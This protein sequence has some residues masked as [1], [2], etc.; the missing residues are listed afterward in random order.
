MRWGR[1]ISVLCLIPLLSACGPYYGVFFVQG[2][3]AED[4]VISVRDCQSGG[5]I[6]EMSLYLRG[7]T[8]S[9]SAERTGKRLLLWRVEVDGGEPVREIGLGGEPDGYTTRH[10]LT[11]EPRAGT[12][13]EIRATTVS[14]RGGGLAFRPERLAAGYVTYDDNVT[15]SREAYDDLPDA[16]FCY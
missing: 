6:T 11:A 5:G 12:T 8:N 7:D 16:W 3:D 15:E 13:Y 4:A 14:G 9:A 2:D 10:P 1:V